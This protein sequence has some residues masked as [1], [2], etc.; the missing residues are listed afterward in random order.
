MCADLI[1][2][3]ESNGYSILDVGCR[4]K[5]LKAFLKGAGDYQGIDLE[6]ADEVIAHDL[7]NRLPME[8]ESF[9]VAVALDVVEHVETAHQLVSE[10]LRVARKKVIVSLPNMYHWKFRINVLLGR[11]IGGKYRFPT[12]SIKDRHRWLTSYNS[13]KGFILANSAGCDV[14]I[15][16]VIIERRWNKPFQL[17][18]YLGAKLFP[19]LFAYGGMYVITKKSH[20]T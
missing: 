7:E 20:T 5:E 8:D 15:L 3:S 4:G 12:H 9:D 18:D 14:T 2:S 10:L 19:N 13:S 17:L 6:E 11:D 16:P 1:N